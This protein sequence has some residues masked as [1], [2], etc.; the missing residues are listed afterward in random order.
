MSRHLRACPDSMQ[1]WRVGCLGGLVK[2]EDSDSGRYIGRLRA[3]KPPTTTA[4]PFI[5]RAGHLKM[6]PLVPRLCLGTHGTRGSASTRAGRACNTW[7]SQAGAWER[8]PFTALPE[9]ARQTGC[10]RFIAPLSIRRRGRLRPDSCTRTHRSR[11]PYGMALH[12]PT[13]RSCGWPSDPRP[14]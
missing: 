3:R 5:G 9:R 10:G 8:E 4:R 11:I 7:R 13:G 2:S 12:S 14:R 1:Y 6:W